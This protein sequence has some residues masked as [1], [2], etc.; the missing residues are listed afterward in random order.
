MKSRCKIL[1]IRRKIW[2]GY[3]QEELGEEKAT[4]GRSKQS[5]QDD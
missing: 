1:A 4:R 3:K 5:K 2:K